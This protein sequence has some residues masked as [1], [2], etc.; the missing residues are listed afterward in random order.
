MSSL[1]R[2]KMNNVYA[3]LVVKFERRLSFSQKINK[4]YKE[5]MKEIL[6]E[7]CIYPEEFVRKT[8]LSRMAYTRLKERENTENESIGCVLHSL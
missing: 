2:G 6:E 4:S 7:R 8:D 3:D 1:I 5:L